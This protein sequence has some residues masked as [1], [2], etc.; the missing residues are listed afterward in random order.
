M[1][2]LSSRPPAHPTQPARHNRKLLVPRN[3]LAHQLPLVP[4]WINQLSVSPA[5]SV[6]SNSFLNARPANAAKKLTLGC[7]R[8]AHHA[9]IATASTRV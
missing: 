1:R 7:G 2:R 9:P 4:E 5:L 8:L 6:T 3:T